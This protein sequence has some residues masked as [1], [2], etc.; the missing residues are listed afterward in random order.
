MKRKYTLQLEQIW[1]RLWLTFLCEVWWSVQGEI[2][3]LRAGQMQNMVMTS[4]SEEIYNWKLV[5]K[6]VFF[7][8]LPDSCISSKL[9]YAGK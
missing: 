9:T 8:T 6:Y 3:F 4:K 7:W 2:Y 5:G 1:F